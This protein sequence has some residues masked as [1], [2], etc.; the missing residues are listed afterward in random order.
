MD[1]KEKC[2]IFEKIESG[3]D[4]GDGD[5]EINDPAA[6]AAGIVRANCALAFPCSCRNYWR[7]VADEEATP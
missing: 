6:F 1:A 4:D 7:D 2:R 5:T 3:E